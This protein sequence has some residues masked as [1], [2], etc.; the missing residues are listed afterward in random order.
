MSKPKQLKAWGTW[1]SNIPANKVAESSPRLASPM[2]IHDDVYW[3]QSLANE[4]GRMGIMRGQKQDFENILPAPYSVRS[5]VHEYGGLSICFSPHSCKRAFFINADDQGLYSFHLDQPQKVELIYKHNSFRF[6]DISYSAKHKCIFAVAEQHQEPQVDNLIVSISLEGQLTIIEQ[7]ADFYAYP[8]IN[9]TEDKLCWI[10]WMHPNMPW[11]A[12]SLHI[13]NIKS[14]SHL[15]RISCYGAAAKGQA[16]VEAS[17]VQPCWASDDS[18]FFISDLSNWWNIW[19]LEGS[20][21]DRPE[22]AIHL[23]KMDAECATPLWVLGMQHLAI[24]NPSELVFA[25]NQEGLWQLAHYNCNTKELKTVGSACSSIND[26]SPVHSKQV[27]FIKGSQTQA[28]YICSVDLEELKTTKHGIKNDQRS[29]TEDLSQAQVMRFGLDEQQCHAFYYAPNNRS[30]IGEGAPPLIALC[31]GGPTGQSDSSLNY[32]IQYWTN[33]GFAV[34]DVNYRGSTGFGRAFRQSLYQNWG[35]YDIEDM[36]K[37]CQS[38]CEQ[39]LANKEQVIIKGSSAGGYTVLAS[40]C[41]SD[42]FKAGVSLYGIGDLESLATDTHKFEQ[43]YLDHLVAPYP[44]GKD[45]YQAL[46]PI[47][48]IEQ[49][50]CPLLLFQG[51][52]DKVVPPN[53]AQAM[54]QSVRGKGLPVAHIEYA[55]EGHGFRQTSTIEHMLEAE[56]YFYQQVFKLSEKVESGPVEIDNLYSEADKT[57]SQHG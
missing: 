14:A 2:L 8:R 51:L 45:R 39:G 3:L 7:G 20:Q 43:H 30:Y 48:N 22:Q 40:L 44:E 24:I 25:Y 5:K 54:A 38:L 29:D 18:L 21:L 1:P 9:S 57:G 4:G 17:I 16:Y 23:C 11:D 28:P 55:G 32:K 46:S 27:T 33:R 12:T 19:K 35:R 56:L 42:V 52:D 37:V 6:A 15:E 10:S 13:A 34:V 31:H 50:N 36:V 49:F 47:H 53:Q 26:L 41:F